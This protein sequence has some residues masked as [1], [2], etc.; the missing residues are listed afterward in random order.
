MGEYLLP[1]L[2][3]A[4]AALIPAAPQTEHQDT[5]NILADDRKIQRKEVEF[6]R[7]PAFA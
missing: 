7:R 5:A 2:E 1:D 4:S 6:F 3:I